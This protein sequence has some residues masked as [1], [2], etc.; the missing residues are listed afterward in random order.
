MKKKL[1]LSKITHLLFSIGLVCFMFIVITIVI[2]TKSAKANHN[3][4]DCG[5]YTSD[6]NEVFS[7]ISSKWNSYKNYVENQTGFNLS[8]CLENR[9][10]KNGDVK[11]KA[12]NNNHAG[13]ATFGLSR[14]KI[15]N[16]WLNNRTSV[17]R[18]RRACVSALMAHEFAHTCFSVEG[19]SD[20]IDEST[21]NWWKNEYNT[22]NSWHSCGIYQ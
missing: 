10:K 4:I 8:G 15:D 11:C 14:I 6:M 3:V 2:T 22:G 7:K 12:L 1:N 19:R 17:Q 21:F 18:D 13:E 20:T 9:F 5:A 16:G